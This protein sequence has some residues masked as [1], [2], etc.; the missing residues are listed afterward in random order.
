MQAFIHWRVHP[1]LRGW[2]GGMLS[3][4]VALGLVVSGFGGTQQIV[5]FDALTRTAMCSLLFEKRAG[6]SSHS[7][8]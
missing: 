5:T 6:W 2:N 3:L 1:V 8:H 7:I 4:C